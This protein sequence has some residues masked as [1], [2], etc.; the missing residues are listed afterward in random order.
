MTLECVLMYSSSSVPY[1]DRLIAS[2]PVVSVARL[3]KDIAS[4]TYSNWQFSS[5]PERIWPPRLHSCVLLLC[6]RVRVSILQVKSH[7]STPRLLLS[8]SVEMWTPW[9]SLS[10]FQHG[11]ETWRHTLSGSSIF[12][13]YVSLLFGVIHRARR[14]QTLRLHEENSTMRIFGTV[15]LGWHLASRKRISCWQ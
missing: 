14:P 3:V 9:N 5:H 13:V 6:T 10:C 7:D 15:L 11:L 2:C 8:V 12:F 1:L 4:T